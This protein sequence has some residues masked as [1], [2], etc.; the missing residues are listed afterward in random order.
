MRTVDPETGQALIAV[1]KLGA[2]YLAKMYSE[3]ADR[4][5]AAVLAEFDKT[6]DQWL[7]QLKHAVATLEKQMEHATTEQRTRLNEVLED[8]CFARVQVNYSYEASREAIDARRGML[9]YAALGAADAGMRGMSIA[10]V[11]RVERTIR[12]LDPRDVRALARMAT[13]FA[14]PL[15]D[16]EGKRSIEENRR[17]RELYDLTSSDAYRASSDV[18]A[19]TAC[20]GSCRYTRKE[21]DWAVRWRINLLGYAVL[22]V[23]DLYLR[24]VPGP[25]EPS[26]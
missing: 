24:A 2:G 1:G 7:I 6:R 17:E 8:P 11:A 5:T 12:E 22:R 9:A 21:L 18:L 15:P 3:F 10:E 19:A 26:E 14:A 23:M 4:N 25:K 16:E 13:I 20:V